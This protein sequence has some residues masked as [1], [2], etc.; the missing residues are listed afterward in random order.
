MKVNKQFIKFYNETF[1][2]IEDIGGGE[3]LG[4]YMRTVCPILIEDLKEIV[5]SEG[6]EGAARYWKEILDAEKVLYTIALTKWNS[7]L[8]PISLKLYIHSC[9]SVKELDSPC[10]SYCMH[11]PIIYGDLFRSLGYEF[12]HTKEG[13]ASCI[14]EIKT[15]E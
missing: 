1:K 12:S 9:P 14:I 4:E 5:K 2:F 7:A 6:L 11:C 13:D 15:K 8:L 3:C 10:D